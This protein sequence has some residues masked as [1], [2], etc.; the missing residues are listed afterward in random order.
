MY[1]CIFNP[2]LLYCTW[3]SA[4]GGEPLGYLL[5]IYRLSIP[6]TLYTLCFDS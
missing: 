1:R 4:S 2:F 6:F 3:G 5:D